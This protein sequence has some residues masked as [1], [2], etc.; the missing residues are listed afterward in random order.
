M[1][2]GEQMLVDVLLFWPRSKVLVF[3]SACLWQ[4]EHSLPLLLSKWGT[5]F[6]SLSL[7]LSVSRSFPFSLMGHWP[8]VLKQLPPEWHTHTHTDHTLHTLYC[9]PQR[10]EPNTHTHT[11]VHTHRGGSGKTAALPKFCLSV[12]DDESGWWL[13]SG[14]ARLTA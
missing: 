4:V 1:D 8:G 3:L 11:H 9:M 5:T 10:I 2:A 12:C 14:A 6:P 7:S 13:V